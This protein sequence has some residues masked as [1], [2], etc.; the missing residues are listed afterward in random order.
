MSFVFTLMTSKTR[1][2]TEGVEAF[3]IPNQPPVKSSM[4]GL[5][6][7]CTQCMSLCTFVCFHTFLIHSVLYIHP[8]GVCEWLCVQVPFT[9]SPQESPS[10]AFSDIWLRTDSLYLQVICPVKPLGAAAVHIITA[11]L[12]LCLE[13]RWN[14][15]VCFR[16]Y[17]YAVYPFI[18]L[19]PRSASHLL[20]I[21][22]QCVFREL[23]LSPSGTDSK[24]RR[25]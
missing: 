9:E 25:F 19:P 24:P 4:C 17:K 22:L 18:L 13:L 2:L 12:R 3:I 23:S 10:G 14:P 1:Q 15:I 20:Q 5:V 16:G 8:V 6:C 21:S 11:F 7:L